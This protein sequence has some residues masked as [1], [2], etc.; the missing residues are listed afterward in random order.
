MALAYQALRD[1]ENRT[2]D[3]E[4]FINR[5]PT[6][7]G[8]NFFR[9]T[10]P[11]FSPGPPPVNMDM[12]LPP[13]PLTKWT[14]HSNW[15]MH[16]VP[17]KMEQPGSPEFAEII[18]WL[19]DEEEHQH[20]CYKQIRDTIQLDLI[21]HRT[22][23]PNAYWNDDPTAAMQRAKTEVN[24]TEFSSKR[25]NSPS[26]MTSDQS[27]RLRKA[28]RSWGVPPG[29]ALI[30][31]MDIRF[32]AFR[33]WMH[34]RPTLASRQ[35]E[36]LHVH[37][38]ATQDPFTGF[39][40]FNRLTVQNAQ[41][42]HH[43][44]REQK[45]QQSHKTALIYAE[46]ACFNPLAS[47][48]LLIP[49]DKPNPRDPEWDE[50]I[51]RELASLKPI[52]DS[53][54]TP[55]PPPL[56]QMHSKALGGGVQAR[57]NYPFKQLST[58]QQRREKAKTTGAPA[59]QVH[60]TRHEEH[61]SQSPPSDA[62]SPFIH[63]RS[64]DGS[65][66]AAS[67]YSL[68]PPGAMRT[69]Y[70]YFR[71]IIDGIPEPIHHYR[72]AGEHRHTTSTDSI[73]HGAF[74]STAD[75]IKIL[76]TPN[77]P[78]CFHRT[79]YGEVLQSVNFPDLNGAIY[80]QILATSTPPVQPTPTTMCSLPECII[81]DQATRRCARCLHSTYHGPRCQNKDFDRHK[82]W[83]KANA[84]PEWNLRTGSNRPR[85]GQR[86]LYERDD[87]TGNRLDQ[88]DVDFRYNRT[89]DALG[90]V[91]QTNHHAKTPKRISPRTY[92]SHT[93]RTSPGEP[94]HGL[95]LSLA[96][97]DK[98]SGFPH[99][100]DVVNAIFNSR[101]TNDQPPPSDFC[102]NPSPRI[103][104]G[105]FHSTDD[106]NDVSEILCMN[107][108]HTHHH[109]H[110]NSADDCSCATQNHGLHKCPHC[111]PG[112]GMSGLCGCN[113]VLYTS[114]FEFAKNG[115]ITQGRTMRPIAHCFF[116]C[117]WQRKISIKLAAYLNYDDK[118]TS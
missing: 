40:L 22:K 77:G 70:E 56:H 10:K 1:L 6:Y 107:G 14:A 61:S 38:L 111:D 72:H 64:A 63:Q 54:S 50:A 82:D 90:R 18:Q 75:E 85:P 92:N 2:W 47:H 27:N 106:A 93:F 19:V 118:Q 110:S 96:A 113:V 65:I 95:D 74:D 108:R 81:K 62:R 117:P 86:G 35:R 51:K 101:I 68:P 53:S 73:I 49:W 102:D 5:H 29:D 34:T 98:S 7:L 32:T 8:N 23:L 55:K 25:I 44:H 84:V 45:S 33:T 16:R 30:V 24:T 57:I 67:K 89:M 97:L 15:P 99:R 37:H 83:C 100:F 52:H 116:G 41:Q 91:F 11:T 31:H 17:P 4:T 39:V 46:H 103:A 20:Q 87:V 109:G 58:G 9:P 88:Y 69:A 21:A 26:Q 71:P 43:Q 66:S 36:L 3:N 115:T 28:L 76:N 48:H 80:Q 112:P 12:C 42:I 94:F 105:E 13:M 59:E 78:R 104:F 79:T 60:A 114:A